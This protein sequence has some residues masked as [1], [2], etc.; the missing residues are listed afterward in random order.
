MAPFDRSYT[1]FYWSAIANMALSGTV[2]SYLT[3]N[4]IMT[5][6]CGL[7]VTQDHSN[8]YHS[9]VWMRLPIRLP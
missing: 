1:T 6:K 4:N 9:K 8:W 3:L 2:L 7:E 5:L